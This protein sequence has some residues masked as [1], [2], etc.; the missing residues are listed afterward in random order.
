MRST[1]IPY[2]FF[3]L[4]LFVGCRDAEQK[5]EER[6]KDEIFAIHDEVMPAT[7]DIMRLSRKIRSVKKK[8]PAL[9]HS[10]T[11]ELDTALFQLEA[12]HDEMMVWMKNFKSPAK[13]RS[14]RTHEE[15]M[16]Y[17][18]QEKRNIEAVRDDMILSLDTGNRVLEKY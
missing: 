9:T 17:L 6:L 3:T 13:L 15:I 2:L 14:A 10:A 16:E 4:I 11:T 1:S 5:A 7:S 12:A 8:N 18:R